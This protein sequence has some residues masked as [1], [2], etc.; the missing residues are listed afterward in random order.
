M[1]KNENL[2]CENSLSREK[3]R[4]REV[5]TSMQ[6][7]EMGRDSGVGLQPRGARLLWDFLFKLYTNSTVRSGVQ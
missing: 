1:K 6:V 4:D 2:A 3:S 7:T 5:R